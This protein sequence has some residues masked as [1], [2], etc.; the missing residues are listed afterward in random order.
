[1]QQ[2]HGVVRYDEVFGNRRSRL[3]VD[4][5]VVILQLVAPFVYDV[6]AILAR[7]VIFGYTYT[8]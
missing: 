8:K 7:D 6:E 2:L 3:R 5:F 4:A 1:M